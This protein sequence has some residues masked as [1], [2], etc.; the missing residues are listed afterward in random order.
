MEIEDAPEV[1]YQATRGAGVA[2][3]VVPPFSAIHGDI[4]LYDLER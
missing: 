3:T 4:A 2:F 1:K